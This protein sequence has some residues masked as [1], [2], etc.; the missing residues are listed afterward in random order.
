M[1]CANRANSTNV[2]RID[3]GLVVKQGDLASSFGFELLDENYQTVPGLD[4]EMATVT[5]TKGVHKWKTRVQVVGSA[6]SFHLDSILPSGKY[7]LEVSVGGY[8]FPSNRATMIHV[9]SSD[10]ELV[11][12]DEL[13]LKELEV[14]KVVEKV[15][16]EK[17]LTPSTEGTGTQAGQGDFPDLLFYYNLGKV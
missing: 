14:E 16:A 15:I 9:E 7:R 10:K 12:E 4:G 6:V 1:L 11:T 17:H 13:K 2:A 3:G 8:V 5:L